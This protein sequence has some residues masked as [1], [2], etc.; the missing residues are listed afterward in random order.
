MTTE[1]LELI[2]LTKLMPNVRNAR[3]H[4][5]PQVNQLRASLREFGFVNPILVDSDLNI[6][7]GHGRLMAAQAEGLKKVPCVFVEYLTEAQKRAYILADNRLA[8]LA[9]WDEELLKAELE[10]LREMNFDVGL[11]GFDDYE[12]K[13]V[14][15]PEDNFDV[16]SEL[17]KPAVAR[18]GD[19]WTL[20]RHK[21]IC[22]DSTEP[23]TFKRLLGGERVNLL[24]TDPPYFVAE[25]NNSGTILNDDLKDEDG[26]KFLR[27]A[28]ENCKGAMANDAA[29]YIFYA[30]SKTRIFF[31]AFED[32]GFHVMAGLVWVKN[33]S[34]LCRGDFNFKHEPIIYGKKRRGTHKWYGDHAQT[35]VLEFPRIMDSAVE[36]CGH[37][38]SKPLPLVS[39]LM[40]LSS[41]RGD[42]ILD[43]FL[44][45]GSTL[46]AAEQLGRTCLGVELD[47]KFVDAA[48][49][50]FKTVS[51]KKISVERDG[52][53]LPPDALIF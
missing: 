30:S 41:K 53:I 45:S 46:I 11:T 4:S 7:A 16:A 6:I 24:L 34:V 2:E 19:V 31:D 23:E 5:V 38:T 33:S 25:E 22:G 9:G 13:T 14:E 21:I 27:A 32:A 52:K 35:T 43:C 37:P 1:K 15:V 17:E 42:K 51:S 20:G 40:T 48:V 18:L 29:A 12:F 3:T 36:G 10:A 50:R 28:F 49:A 44:G 47:P 8:E 39:Y 26:Y